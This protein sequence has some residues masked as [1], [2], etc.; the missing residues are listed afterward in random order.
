M[1]A[2]DTATDP[3]PAPPPSATP[4]RRR[5][6]PA[7]VAAA[8]LSATALVGL[9][10]IEWRAGVLHP[11]VIPF[12]LLLL[13]LGVA[14]IGVL[15]LGLSRLARGPHRAN[16]AAWVLA[17]T[18][19]LVGIAIRV[20]QARRDWGRREARVTPVNRLVALAS[21]SLME[22]QARFLYPHRVETDRLVMFHHGVA[23]PREDAERME[24]HVAAVEAAVGRPLRGKIYWV[25]GSLLGQGS[26][27]MYGLALGSERSN[28]SDIV[29]NPELVLDRHELAHA[30]LNQFEHPDAR[31]PSF[32][33]EGWA[34][35]HSYAFPESVL[36]ERRREA[37]ELRGQ[38]RW[39][40][41]RDLCG[42]DWYDRHRGPVYMQGHLWAEFLLRR[43]GADRFIDFCNTCR[44][45]TFDADCRRVFRAGADELE[46]LF[47]DDVTQKIRPDLPHAGS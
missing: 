38:G 46:Q 47:W 6:V 32:L 42:P 29:E 21:A 27:S 19:P 7:A 34:E 17:G 15:V 45:A 11:W 9:L 25:R 22:A 14:T 12:L 26:L 40:S 44:P 20:E 8:W 13:A 23:T 3:A 10:L 30:V 33:N 28:P 31:A 2:S 18:L 43:Y 41:F 1:A 16:A 35:C 4:R 39:L 37:L 5:A 36:A 24:R